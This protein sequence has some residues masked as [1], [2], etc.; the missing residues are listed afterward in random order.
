MRRRKLKNNLKK[1]F[2]VV[3]GIMAV[4]STMLYAF[5]KPSA[6]YAVLF[7]LGMACV[8]AFVKANGV[9]CYDR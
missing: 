2:A 8:M 3:M 7:F 6:I 5:Y 4:A 1:G 9:R